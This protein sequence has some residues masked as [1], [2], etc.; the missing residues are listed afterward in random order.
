MGIWDRATYP[1]P[2]YTRKLVIFII[3]RKI[4][5]DSKKIDYTVILKTISG[6]PLGQIPQNAIKEIS[7]DIN[8]IYT[9][10][11]KIPKFYM[12]LLTFKEKTYPLFKEIKNERQIEVNNSEVFVIKSIE[13]TGDEYLEIKGK[14]RQVRLKDID[15]ELEDVAYSLVDKSNDK[16][17]LCLSDHLQEETGWTIQATDLV[18]Y[19]FPA[20]PYIDRYK[21]IL[22]NLKKRAE[23]D[24]SHEQYALKTKQISDLIE[25]DKKELKEALEKDIEKKSRQL[26]EDGFE[27]IK[28]R[29]SEKKA[30]LEE[31]ITKVDNIG[32]PALDFEDEF[33]KLKIKPKIRYIESV[34]KKWLDFIEKDICESYECC[35]DYDTANKSVLLFM[36]EE[37]IDHIGLY[38]SKDNY[39]KSLEK[40]YDTDKLVTRLVVEGNEDMDIISATCTGEKY[41]EDYSYFMDINEMSDE[42]KNALIKYYDMVEKREPIWRLYVDEIN[43]KE[44]QKELLS[45][46]FIAVESALYNLNNELELYSLP[47]KDKEIVAKI[48]AAITQHQDKRIEI[49]NAIDRLE[50]LIKNLKK[51]RD[52]ITILCKKPTATDDNGHL[53]FTPALLNELKEY[54]YTETYKNPSF[55]TEYIEDLMVLSKRILRDKSHPTKKWDI[56]VANFLSRLTSVD[57]LSWAGNLALGDLIILYDKDEN[58]EEFVY[59]VGYTHNVTD[60]SLKIRLSNKKTEKEDG[61]TIADYL[62]SAKNSMRDIES[63]KYL[64]MQQKYKRLNV[65]REFIAKYNEPK[66]KRPNGTIID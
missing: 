60:N 59:F 56:D 43:H 40:E 25:K 29:I 19:E 12:D 54:I 63:K 28:T 53:I 24:E 3:N 10:N 22:V 6:K 16:D 2:F 55:L 31:L 9:I 45:H 38:L 7:K 15:M 36:E 50:E 37:M 13:V 34:N 21:R 33:N 5:L 57:G 32:S 20:D 61:L 42:L 64:A 11:L 62:T 4:Q 1:L 58:V 17:Q 8:S 47:P 23:I 51:A 49:K 26:Q 41:L 65:P 30:K 35:V 39:I 48:V 18:R 66:K 27:L 44:N 46:D 52:N 14:S